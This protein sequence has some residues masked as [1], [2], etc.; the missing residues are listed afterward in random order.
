MATP[1]SGRELRSKVIQ[2]LQTQQGRICAAASARRLWDRVLSPEERERLG[3]DLQQC[4]SRLGTVGMWTE[5]RGVSPERAVVDVA[6]ELGFLDEP[7]AKWLL[8]ETGEQAPSSRSGE[9]PSWDPERGEL[10]LGNRIIRRVRI[11]AGPSNIQQI[12]DTFE[13]E[14]WPGR[15]DNPLTY[16]RQQ[17]YQALRSLNT[18]LEAIRFHAQKG[19][20]VIVWKRL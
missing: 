18:R 3:G 10:R 1:S 2:E 9:V 15:I 4:Y 20:R 6:R 11:M 14:G 19:G 12:L 7:T 16:G 13:T 8:R 17:T 5:L